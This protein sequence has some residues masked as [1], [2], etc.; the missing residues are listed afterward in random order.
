MVRH[1]EV[2]LG[3]Y[4]LIS[5]MIINE[6]SERNGEI[7]IHV[8]KF[9]LYLVER[10]NSHTRCTCLLWKLHRPS[11]G[12]S[13]TLWRIVPCL[14]IYLPIRPKKL[15]MVLTTWNVGTGFAGGM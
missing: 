8:F 2:Y 7:Y 3:V 6:A 13:V 9:V 4:V 12:L 14:I 10:T 5:F 1:F 15:A 11:Y